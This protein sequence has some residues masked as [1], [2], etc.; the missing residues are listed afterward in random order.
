MHVLASLPA[1][2][3][4]R[5]KILIAGTSAYSRHIDYEKMRKIADSVRPSSFP[6]LPR[7]CE[8]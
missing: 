4:P 8:L 3:C 2:T 5:P 7:E 6:L 1:R